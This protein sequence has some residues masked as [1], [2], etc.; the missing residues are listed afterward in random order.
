MLG[1]SI[2]DVKFDP[3]EL[4]DLQKIGDQDMDVSF[5]FETAVNE[6]CSFL[7]C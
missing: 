6:W 4:L 2:A 1:D 3:D 5:A 7:S